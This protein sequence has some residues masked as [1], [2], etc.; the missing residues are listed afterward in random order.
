MKTSQFEL[1]SGIEI[2][3]VQQLIRLSTKV[4]II[5]FTYHTITIEKHTE[6]MTQTQ[7]TQTQKIPRFTSS[8][9]TGIKNSP[10]ITDESIKKYL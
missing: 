7:L 9:F 10:R 8:G 5:L 2:Y 1:A 3:Q 4:N 6:H